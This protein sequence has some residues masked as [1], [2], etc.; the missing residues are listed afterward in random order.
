MSDARWFEIESA[1]DAAVRH[2]AGAKD[3]FQKLPNLHN[4]TDRYG[5]EMGFMHA[6]QSGQTAL[7]MALLYIFDLCGE[8]A[9]TGSRW[10]ADLIARAAHPVGKR[11]A[12]LDEE[13]ARAA[14]ETRRF[15]SIAAHPDD[16]FD[17][18]QAT[19]ALA[20]A[21][22]LVSLLPSEIARFRGE[23]DP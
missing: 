18:E 21:T 4:P 14:N 23:I 12:I 3:L 8:E 9:P 16:A 20:S 11:M 1:V 13:V 17:H 5:F 22:L 19:R 2:F 15:R 7:E 10:H 6:M